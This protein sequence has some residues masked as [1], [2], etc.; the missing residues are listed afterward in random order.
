MW[1]QIVDI[2]NGILGIFPHFDLNA[3]AVLEHEDA[4]QRERDRR[5]LI[6]FDAAVIVRLQKAHAAL[7]IQRN[8]LDVDARRIDMRGDDAHAV[9]LQ[10]ARADAEYDDGLPAVDEILFVPRRK[11]IAEMI[12]GKALLLRHGD[13]NVAC[14]ALR[15]G[16]V[17]KR[18]VAL[19]I[20]V[21]RLAF[22]LGGFFVIVLLFVSEL[23]VALFCLFLFIS[24]KNNSLF[25][26]S[27]IL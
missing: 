11:R 16:G 2:E 22:L 12:L 1:K 27:D 21:D 25:V 6:L 10:I 19:R 24:H 23:F 8:L 7:F 17:E 9:R 13:R 15:L 20:G 4:V 18:L 5:P 14:L 3:R 26:F